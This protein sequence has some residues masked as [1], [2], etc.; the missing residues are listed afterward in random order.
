M[1]LWDDASDTSSSSNIQTSNSGTELALMT[2]DQMV[3]YDLNNQELVH[4]DTDALLDSLD[5]CE[6]IVVAAYTVANYVP[7]LSNNEYATFW[8]ND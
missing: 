3:I 1:S 8:K 4:S 6:K 5:A 7:D 2:P